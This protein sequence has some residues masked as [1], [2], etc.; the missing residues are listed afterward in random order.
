MA[1]AEDEAFLVEET[2]AGVVAEIEGDG[3]ESAGVVCTAEDVGGDGDV[4]T[5]CV[6]GAT[7]LCV[8]CGVAGLRKR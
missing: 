8:G 6:G 2:R 7:A 3:V 1:A 4:F 5:A